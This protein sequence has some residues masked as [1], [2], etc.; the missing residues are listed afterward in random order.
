MFRNWVSKVFR[1]RRQFP[2]INKAKRPIKRSARLLL[3][4]L[5]G[6]LAPATLTVNSTDDFNSI[7]TGHT[8]VTLR[9]AIVDAVTLTTD[10]NGETPTGNDTIVFDPSVQ[11][12][13]FNLKYDSTNDGSG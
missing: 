1:A 13:T 3:E 9:D 11:G 4:E 7:N 5:E 12:A 6:R 8:G 10:N 2:I